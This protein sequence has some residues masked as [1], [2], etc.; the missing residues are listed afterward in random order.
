M[1][2][3]TKIYT[4]TGDQGTTALGT[5]ARVPKNH[6]R[7]EA[8]GTADEL[9]A[10]LGVALAAG[11][12]PRLAEMLPRVQ[13]SLFHLG[14]DLAFPD[15]GEKQK[16]QVPRIEARHVSELEGWID[17]L[18]EIV[19]PLQNFALP[20]GALGAALLHQARTICRRA[21][22]VLV[23]LGEKEPEALSST[24]LAY[25]NRLSDF[26]FVAA[27]Y[28]NHYRRTPEPLWDTLA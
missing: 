16:Y 10:V 27:R 13:N 1:P 8:F 21:E 5:K 20:G 26:L 23:V 3:L 11:L 15:E 7:V 17:E 28:E 6:P 24:N 12:A 9:N 22:R 19:G 14:S 2:R 25:L 18:N 4:R